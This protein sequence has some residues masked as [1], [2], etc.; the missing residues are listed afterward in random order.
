MIIIIITTTT[1]ITMIIIIIIIIIMIALI[2][3][4]RMI[5]I[6]IINVS[7]GRSCEVSTRFR[8]AGRNEQA[9]HHIIGMGGLAMSAS[10]AIRREVVD[11]EMS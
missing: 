7:Q 2:R 10:T 4:I 6:T 1:I 8:T 3:M 9:C 11:P 5:L